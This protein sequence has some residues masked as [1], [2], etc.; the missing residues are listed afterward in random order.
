MARRDYSDRTL[1]LLFGRAPCCAFPGCWKPLAD[2]AGDENVTVAQVAHIEG[3][4]PLSARY[5]P[6][7][8]NA[9]RNDYP[10][11]LL[12]CPTH[13]MAYVDAAPKTYTVDDLRGWKRQSEQWLRDRLREAMPQ[14]TFAELDVVMKAVAGSQGAA[15]S[16]LRLVPPAEK[17][18]KNG[19]TEASNLSMGLA[20][21]PEVRRLLQGH[22]ALDPHFPERLREGFV[23]EYRRL[24]DAG[25]R[26][27]DLF[28]GLRAFAVG[29]WR[30]SFPMQ[31]AALA[32]LS[33]LFEACEVFER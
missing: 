22:A 27:D 16:D 24:H 31:D 9:E 19:L 28:L 4:E 13:H 23:A 12:L 21:A 8:T 14:V 18:K 3:L 26:G 15:T 20:K 11:L 2:V 29:G 25:E 17:M 30:A 6:A 1:K 33:Y 32:V 7:M 5:N 10:N